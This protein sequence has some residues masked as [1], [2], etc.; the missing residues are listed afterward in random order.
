MASDDYVDVPT[1][2]IVWYERINPPTNQVSSSASSAPVASLDEI[3][4]AASMRS[5]IDHDLVIG[6]IRAESGFDA[7][8]V[9][10]KGAKRLM[11]LM[12]QTATRLG[13]TPWILP[14]TWKGQP[15]T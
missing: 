13:V 12:P 1:E 11:Q 5:K 14:L 10:A 2:E 7:N 8:A 3:I 15:A 4:D 9:S 6:L